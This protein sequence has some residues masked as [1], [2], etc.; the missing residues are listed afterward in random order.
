MPPSYDA[1]GSRSSL[2]YARLSSSFAPAADLAV[3]GSRG[4]P[5]HCRSLRKSPRFLTSIPGIGSALPARSEGHGKSPAQ[6]GHRPQGFGS[7][8]SGS[9]TT[10]PITLLASRK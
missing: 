7:P 9:D 3:G 6:G 1:G 5:A 4:R 2:Y 10:L 8:P